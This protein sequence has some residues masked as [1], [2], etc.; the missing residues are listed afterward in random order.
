M[1][2]SKKAG[3]T[4]EAPN[5]FYVGLLESESMQRELLE[6]R[7]NALVL[8]K[9]L[10]KAILIREQR[11]Y[12]EGEL[13]SAISTLSDEIGKVMSNL[14]DLPAERP[15]PNKPKPADKDEPSAKPKPEPKQLS[16]LDRK[17]AEIDKRLSDLR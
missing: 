12:L 14:P 6:A 17:L 16:E 1:M 8:L 15:K 4:Q 3:K 9:R 2:A 10:E 7:K 13:R 5:E 11:L